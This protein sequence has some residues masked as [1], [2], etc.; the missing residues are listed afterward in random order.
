MDAIQSSKKPTIVDL[1][2]S[3]ARITRSRAV[4][5]SSRNTHGERSHADLSLG[6]TKVQCGSGGGGSDNTRRKLQDQ[7]TV[8]PKTAP[9]GSSTSGKRN[10]MTSL[11]SLRVDGT[12]SR[13]V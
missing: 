8:T 10:D 9:T 7:S 5:P 13:E 12:R 3:S 2:G 1:A 11:R 6:V 4:L